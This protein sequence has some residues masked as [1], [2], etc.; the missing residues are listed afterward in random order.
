[1]KYIQNTQQ[2]QIIDLCFND[3]SGLGATTCLNDK[4]E[5]LLTSLTQGG[6][7]GEIQLVYDNLDY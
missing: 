1:M 4:Y 3:W 7:G 5:K 2:Q 6:N